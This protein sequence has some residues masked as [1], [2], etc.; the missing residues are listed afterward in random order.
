[1]TRRDDAAGQSQQLEILLTVTGGRGGQ[2]TES[3]ASANAHDS[4][5]PRTYRVAASVA[6]P[7]GCELHRLPE[8]KPGVTRVV[9]IS[10]RSR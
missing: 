8:L 4:M 7:G 1:M 9:A 5:A 10:R 3:R 2:P 6:L